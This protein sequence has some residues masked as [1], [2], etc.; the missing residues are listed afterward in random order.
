MFV[1]PHSELIREPGLLIPRRKPAGPVA[2][3]RSHPLAPSDYWLLNRRYGLA[4]LANPANP[5]LPV[6]SYDWRQDDLCYDGS[7]QI[8]NHLVAAQSYNTTAMASGSSNFFLISF[9]NHNIIT[10]TGYLSMGANYF[11][12]SPFFFFYS[13]APADNHEAFCDGGYK[14]TS[15]T[16]DRNGHRST[17]AIQFRASGYITVYLDFE[18]KL[19]ANYGTFAHTAAADY[20]FLNS[21]Y[22]RSGEAYIEYYYCYV[23]LDT[24]YSDE[25]AIRLMRDPYQFLVPA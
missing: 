17:M 14:Y 11:D 10:D 25:Q 22:K 8:T 12:S 5:L 3:N 13:D 6:G 4:N 20:L 15:D 16:I 19:Y 18:V 7:S 23:A 9:T 1:H 24:E 21:S 2:I